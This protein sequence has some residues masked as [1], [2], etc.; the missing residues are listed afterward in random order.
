M[1]EMLPPT[2]KQNKR[3]RPFCLWK[4]IALE[5]MP[6]L[7]SLVVS[8]A[9]YSRLFVADAKKANHTS[10]HTRENSFSSIT[11]HSKDR[12]HQVNPN[13][14]TYVLVFFSL[15]SSFHQQ[16]L[17]VSDC[18]LFLVSCSSTRRF[19]NPDPQFS[20]LS[21]LSSF[22]K[23]HE[24]FW[25]TLLRKCI[26]STGQSLGRMPM[27]SA[28]SRSSAH[29]QAERWACQFYPDPMVWGRSSFSIDP[30][31]RCFSLSFPKDP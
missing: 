2:W 21:L 15:I 12:K 29:L 22:I 18:L 7:C 24:E 31:N 27:A 3:E 10:F 4:Y 20:N 28:R 17:F 13:Q 14:G 23:P 9:Y 19:S 16:I 8:C 1:P 30:N 26:S 5:D 6:A 11:R 25:L